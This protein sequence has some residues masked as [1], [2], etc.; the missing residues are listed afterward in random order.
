MSRPDLSQA[1]VAIGVEK[2]KLSPES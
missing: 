2:A 1:G